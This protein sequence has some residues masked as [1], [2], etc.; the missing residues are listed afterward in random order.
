MGG[1]QS[2]SRGSAYGVDECD[3][4]ADEHDTTTTTP[5]WGGGCPIGGGGGLYQKAH[6]VLEPRLRDCSCAIAHRHGLLGVFSGNKV[7]RPVWVSRVMNARTWTK[8]GFFGF[9]AF[10]R[11]EG[12][13][14]PVIVIAKKH[15]VRDSMDK[16]AV[17]LV[18][19]MF[20]YVMNEA[21]VQDRIP[22]LTLDYI[23]REGND[24]AFKVPASCVHH[25]TALVVAILRYTNNE[26]HV[27]ILYRG[28]SDVVVR[29]QDGT[30]QKR[31]AI[32]P[33]TMCIPWSSVVGETA[34]EY[35]PYKE[36]IDMFKKNNKTLLEGAVSTMVDGGQQATPAVQTPYSIL[37]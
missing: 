10:M 4:V 26:R 34:P 8:D 27:Y 24:V 32:V 18:N 28:G 35:A 31:R 14:H 29:L 17:V 36:A 1:K 11:L 7:I 9:P 2:M 21:A 15:C 30:E 25:V 37:H 13:D 16:Y 19:Q 3:I 6:K 22:Q 20:E 12:V 5:L 33:Y 23:S